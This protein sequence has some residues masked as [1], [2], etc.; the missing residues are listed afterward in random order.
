MKFKTKRIALFTSALLSFVGSFV[1]LWFFMYISWNSTAKEYS[2]AVLAEEEM[3]GYINIAVA[4]FF[5]IFGT[6]CVCRGVLM[7]ENGAEGSK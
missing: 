6:Y 4:V 7:K 1:F 3:K 5:L 2:G